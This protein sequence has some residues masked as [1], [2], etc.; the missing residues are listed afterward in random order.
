MNALTELNVEPPEDNTTLTIA[1]ALEIVAGWNDLPDKRVQKLLTA[2]ATAARVLDPTQPKAAAAAHVQMDCHSL[3]RLLQAPAATFGLSSGRMTSLCS[4]LRAVLRRLDRHEPNRRGAVLQS[5]ALQ[6]CQA[7]LPPHHQ[8]AVVDFLRFLDTEQIPPQAANGGTLG[9]YQ[10]RCSERTLCADPAARARQVAAAWNWACEN[11]PDWPGQKLTRA[12]RTDRYSFPLETYPLPFQQD[13]RAYGDRL[14]GD[15]LDYIFDEDIFVEEDDGAAPRF[16][17]PLRSSSIKSRL[18]F[19]RCAAGALVSTGVDQ[20]Q[21]TSLRHLV[22]PLDRPEAIIRFFMKRVGNGKSSAMSERIAQTLLLLGRD[23]CGLKASDVARLATWRD[24]VTPPAPTGLTE[25]NLRRLRA[26]IQPRA[27]AMILNFPQELMRRSAAPHMTPHDAARLAM[28]AVAM[29]ILLICPMRRK[30]LAEL[31]LDRHLYRPDPRGKRLTHL[32]I[33]AGDVKNSNAI[34]WP[35]PP[36]S[37]RLI[38]TF[39]TQH[40]PHLAEPGNPYLFGTADRQRSAQHLGEWLAGAI[41]ASIGVEFNVHLARHFAAWNFLRENPGQYEVVRQVLGHRNINVTIAYYVGL[42][43]D[44]AAQHF[45]ATVLR[46]R[47]AGRKLA[48]HAFR[49]AAPR[50]NRT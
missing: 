5:T 28:Y 50:K 22:Y 20:Q 19:V 7:A 17:R 3:S 25:K 40:R 33:D 41:T 18:W 2:L 37:A 31:R 24:R 38:E 34:Q 35:I 26:L 23:Y 11:V 14:R 15:D 12:G 21:I 6:A 13:V 45:D 16:Q 29:E 47:H 48:A 39:L 4:E 32:M 43:A 9:A 27:R 8:L 49:Q 44:S 36:E 10:T 1:D 46:D 30:N 42:E